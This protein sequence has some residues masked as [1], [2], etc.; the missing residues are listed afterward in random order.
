MGRPWCPRLWGSRPRCSPTAHGSRFAS[1][2][3]VTDGAGGAG[4]A[5]SSRP[6]RGHAACGVTAF[7]GADHVLSLGLKLRSSQPRGQERR[8]RAPG[9]ATATAVRE[10]RPPSP[11]PASGCGRTGRVDS[12]SPCKPSCKAP[13]WGRAPGRAPGAHAPHPHPTEPRPGVPQALRARPLSTPRL[14]K[15]LSAARWGTGLGSGPGLSPPARAPGASVPAA[16]AP[17]T[18]PRQDAVQPGRPEPSGATSE[19]EVS[20]SQPGG[21]G[22]EE[23][24]RASSVFPLNSKFSCGGCTAPGHRTE[25]PVFAGAAF[26][27]LELEHKQMHF[28]PRAA[29]HVCAL[30]GPQQR[31]ATCGG[32]EGTLSP[33]AACSWH[34]GNGGSARGGALLSR[35]PGT[36]AVLARAA[37]S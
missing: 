23:E 19:G 20:R 35:P 15:E 29:R 26:S 3:P 14:C 36:P 11:G 22:G 31:G 27:A 37:L 21:D 16:E 9:T 6:R 1:R 25:E 10:I 7:P 32:P 2:P 4:A 24:G 8:K 34:G 13:C 33:P 5:P 30:P 17:A 28:V 12:Y 18:L